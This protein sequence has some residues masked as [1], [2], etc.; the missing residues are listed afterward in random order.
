MAMVHRGNKRYFYRSV[1]VNGRVTKVYGGEGEAA[2]RAF[3]AHK[4]EQEARKA[5]RAEWEAENAHFRYCQALIKGAIIVA[6]HLNLLEGWHFSAG[7][8]RRMSKRLVRRQPKEI[9]RAIRT[10]RSAS[11]PTLPNS[12]L[13]TIPQSANPENP[14]STNLQ[15]TK[16]PFKIVQIPPQKPADPPH[17]AAI[18]SD[19]PILQA[20]HGETQAQPDLVGR[21]GSLGV[22]LRG[23]QAALS[24]RPHHPRH[25][26]P[27]PVDSHDRIPSRR[28]PGQKAPP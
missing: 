28:M 5:R 4:K 23:P 21:H 16:S 12:P 13:P 7:E 6:R 26:R 25:R 14:C 3:E 17:L 11:V 18:Q 1:R 15:T 27:R 24:R 20:D 8:Y 22:Q 2:D 19:P 9:R 10:H